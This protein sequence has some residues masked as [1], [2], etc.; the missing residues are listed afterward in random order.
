M[1]TNASYRYQL[2]RVCTPEI[3]ESF[4]PE[5]TENVKNDYFSTAR[6]GHPV[7]C[8]G[9]AT[10]DGDRQH[11]PPFVDVTYYISNTYELFLELPHPSRTG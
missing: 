2:G 9:N 1:H 4:G 5:T 6:R 7:A 3:G 10:I 11:L 8:A